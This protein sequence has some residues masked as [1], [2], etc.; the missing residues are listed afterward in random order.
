M[1]MTLWTLLALVLFLILMGFLK[2]PQWIGAKLDERSQHIANDLAQAQQ[3]REE[4][5]EILAQCKRKSAEA[6][7]QADE[8]LAQA[9]HEANSLL[10]QARIKM[11]DYVERRQKQAEDKI[12]RAES[13]AIAQ[14]KARVVDV[15]TNA[16]ESLM[17][18]TVG[19]KQSHDEQ[20][21]SALKE[22]RSRFK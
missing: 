18:A 22:V 1:D 13:E 20:F 4:A 14:L 2:V 7:K 21:D 3:L 16:A 8:I 10:E 5:Q 15:A 11:Q 17:R 19:E 12:S 6:Q 9:Q